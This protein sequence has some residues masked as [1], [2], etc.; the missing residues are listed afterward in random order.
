[1]DTQ[2]IS[3]PIQNMEEPQQPKQYEPMEVKHIP[4]IGLKLKQE[5][6]DLINEVLDERYE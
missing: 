2:G 5:L 4:M 3:L 6:K 1:M